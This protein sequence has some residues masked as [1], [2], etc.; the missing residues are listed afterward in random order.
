MSMLTLTG[1]SRRIH[2][3]DEGYGLPFKTCKLMATPLTVHAVPVIVWVLIVEH[4]S[5]SIQSNAVLASTDPFENLDQ[6]RCASLMLR[7][8][9]LLSISQSLLIKTL[10]SSN[11]IVTQ[12]Q[13]NSSGLMVQTKKTRRNFT[14]L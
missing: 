7:E 9:G 5:T 11:K 13:N 12:K 3:N 1:T 14:R 8:H 6:R 2:P 10:L 4:G